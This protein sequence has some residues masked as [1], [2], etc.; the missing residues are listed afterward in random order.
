M[1]PA[2]E[3]LNMKNVFQTARPNRYWSTILVRLM[4]LTALVSVLLAF[5]SLT[6]AQEKSPTVQR[7]LKKAQAAVAEVQRRVEAGEVPQDVIDE[8][9]KL[10]GLMQAGKHKDAETLLDDSLVALNID[11]KTLIRKSTKG[12]PAKR[13]TSAARRP[14]P[15]FNPAGFS[16]IF[17][18]KTLGNWGGD[19][20]YWK[21]EAGTLVGEVTPE[22]LLKQN[23]W[24]VWRGGVVE[25][26]E[27]VLDYRVSAQGNS[28][29]G[30]RL[31][32]VEGQRFAVRGPQ[33][34]IHGGNMFTGIC[35]EENGR[36]L[37][38][39]RGQSTWIDDPGTKPRL[40]A[41]IGDPEELQGVVRKED[42][43]RYRLVVKGND[44]RHFINGVLMSEVHDHDKTNRMKKGLLGVQVHVG[45]PMKI[46]F[47]NV[48]LKHLGTPPRGDASL[49]SVSYRPGDLLELD[50]PSSFKHF[51]QQTA[52]LTAPVTKEKINGRTELN[53]VTRNL[54]IVRHDLMNLKLYGGSK[55]ELSKER[56][57]DLVVMT[58]DFVVRVPNAGSRLIGKPLDK[59]YRVRLKWN[60]D[61]NHYDLVDLSPAKQVPAKK[62]AINEQSFR[63][64]D[65]AVLR[66]KIG[67]ALP[68][69]A[70]D[71]QTFIM[72]PTRPDRARELHVS[73]NGAWAGIPG[74][75]SILPHNPDIQKDV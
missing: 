64:A 34:D 6:D 14:L 59:D 28:G 57:Y 39:A 19:P 55:P 26:F 71:A 30:Y 40:L 53:I 4:T 8:L 24:I 44:A 74:K 46:E 60:D 23:S 43:N 25:D 18:G 56:A 58:S 62:P 47:R 31:A 37:L 9:Q 35:Y 33:A 11:P 3:S 51:I 12:A 13:G 68:S 66:K 1:T 20:K 49:G 21:V 48:Y 7:L 29:I 63:L 36:R 75:Y 41:Q 54:G 22:T 50:H 5:Y 65:P 10:D 45:P 2:S 69:W 73:V 72:L 42:W 15:K 38:A 17:D 32:E 52:K 27:L 16:K 70:D 67:L 61:E